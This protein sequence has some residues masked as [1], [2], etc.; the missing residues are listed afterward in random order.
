M[1]FASI[2][3]TPIRILGEEYLSEPLI[4]ERG[5]NGRRSDYEICYGLSDTG[6]YSADTKAFSG[7]L[8]IARGTYIMT[9]YMV[10]D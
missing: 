8:V 4:R 5:G 7:T 9:T 6:R 10:K 1:T 3:H 2:I